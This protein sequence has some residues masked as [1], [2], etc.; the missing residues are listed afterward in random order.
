M[1]N[2]RDKNDKEIREGDTVRLEWNNEIVE[3]MVESRGMSYVIELH[4]QMVSLDNISSAA[5]EI[6]DKRIAP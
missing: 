4:G 6:V 1:S 3:E 2:Y 5:L